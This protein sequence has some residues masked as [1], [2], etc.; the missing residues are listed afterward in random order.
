MIQ[1]LRH[2]SADK[3]AHTKAVE[4]STQI[5]VKTLTGK[6]NAL[7]FE[8]SETLDNVKQKIQ[9]KEGVPPDQQQLTYAEKTL[10]DGRTHSDYNIQKNQFF[11]LP[12][13]RSDQFDKRDGIGIIAGAHTID[14]C[15]DCTDRNQHLRPH[16]RCHSGKHVG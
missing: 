2:L 14:C 4:C 13:G 7:E 16:L 3:L 6:T 15:G 12:C 5:C 11:T 10:E 9:D 8:P 1:G